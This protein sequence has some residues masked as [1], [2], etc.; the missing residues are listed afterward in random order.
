VGDFESSRQ[1]YSRLRECI[2]D[3]WHYDKQDCSMVLKKQYKV[4]SFLSE[5]ETEWIDNST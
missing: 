1:N 4:L 3:I 2:V 5:D